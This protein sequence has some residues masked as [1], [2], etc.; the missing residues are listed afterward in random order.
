MEEKIFLNQNELAT[1]TLD[2]KRLLDT[3]IFGSRTLGVKDV[4]VGGYW[5][6]CNGQHYKED[7]I[8]EEYKEAF[9]L[10]S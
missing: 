5:V 1:H 2:S 7:E 8:I 6:I 3:W 10:R 4:C 9:N